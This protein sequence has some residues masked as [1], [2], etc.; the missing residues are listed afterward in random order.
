MQANHNNGESRL[1]KIGRFFARNNYLWSMIYAQIAAQIVAIPCIIFFDEIFPLEGFAYTFATVAIAIVFVGYFR[2]KKLEVKDGYFKT[3]FALFL[4]IALAAISFNIAYIDDSLLYK[5]YG[6]G[7][8]FL[9]YFTALIN[10]VYFLAF[11]VF[12]WVGNFKIYCAF[13]T[14]VSCA[15]A[16]GFAY[17][18]YKKRFAIANKKPIYISLGIIALI[19]TPPIIFAIYEN[20]FIVSKDI[21][22]IEPIN[23]YMKQAK[24]QENITALRGEPSVYFESALPKLGGATAL[25]PIFVSAAKALYKKPDNLDEAQF[26][27]NYFACYSTPLAYRMLERKQVELIFVIAPSSDQLA[28]AKKAGVEFELTPIGKEAFVFLVSDANPVKSLT[29][30]Q[31]QKIYTGEITNW[32]EVG[33]ADEKILAFQRN[34]NSGSQTAMENSVMKGLTLQEPLKE[35][36]R[37]DMGGLVDAIAD[38]RNA[39]N[40]IGYSFRFYVTDML[41]AKNV[42]LLAINGIEPTADNIRNGLYPLIH[43]FYIVG[44]KNNI[45]ENAQKLIDWF[46]SDQGQALI[47]DV[48]Y[49]PINDIPIND[50]PTNK[51]NR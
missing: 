22:K 6:D 1:K 37:G 17:G 42:R 49:I 44:R 33:G 32:R 25:C 4:P 5:F 51:G 20:S 39:E 21:K 14:I 12:L 2:S 8:G 31:I 10:A 19:L 48:G 38:Y 26:I 46:L 30:E 36:R 40:A 23:E 27:N 29:I 18:L 41:K 45:S 35:M 34:K 9:Y 43:E 28:E 15:Y 11:F 50:I 16:I 7:L 47:E 13:I 24:A 3:Y